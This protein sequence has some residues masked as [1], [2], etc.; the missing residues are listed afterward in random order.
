MASMIMSGKLRHDAFGEGA[1][2]ALDLGA[3][4]SVALIEPADD[5]REPELVA[6]GLQPIDHLHSIAENG[7]ITAELFV[8]Q[9][10]H[11]LVDRL[12]PRQVLAI[13]RRYLREDRLEVAIVLLHT[14]A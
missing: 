7:V 5:L 1:H 9:V 12:E 8:R 13:A 6:R 3:R 4:Q 11:R 14:R 2:R 10:G